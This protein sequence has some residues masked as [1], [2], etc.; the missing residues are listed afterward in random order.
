MGT[1]MRGPAARDTARAMSQENVEIVRR[2]FEAF[3]RG[4]ISALVE[5]GDPEIVSC[6]H[7]RA[8]ATYKGID[9]SLKMIADWVEDFDEFVA[10]PAEYIDA[11]DCVIVRVHEQAR[12][13]GSGVPVEED[14]WFVLRLRDGKAVRWDIYDIK[15]EALEAAGVL[16]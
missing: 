1:S 15:A 3:M 12:G 6:V 11:D 7:P 16:E 9:G 5:L 14:W 13:K 8:N 2:G 4:D 10:E